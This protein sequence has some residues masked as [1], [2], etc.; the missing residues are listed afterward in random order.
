[1]KHW[2]HSA[3]YFSWTA[4]LLLAW[5]ALAQK[6]SFPLRLGDIFPALAGQTLSGK[7]LN[8]PVAARDGVAV[9]IVSFSRAGGRDAQNWT[10]RFAKDH[11]LLA[12][13]NV[14]FLESVPRPFRNLAVSGIRNGMPPAVHD[15]TVL[16]YGEQASWR[17]RLQVQDLDN[18]SVVVLGPTGRIRW[19]FSGRFTEANY[20]RAE[21]EIEP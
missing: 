20:R 13:Y 18:A 7:Q 6:E 4:L 17:E 21:R 16:L 10:Q 5:T 8:L 19:I 1:M 12:T 15:R 2:T 3:L 9:M 14:I 11:P